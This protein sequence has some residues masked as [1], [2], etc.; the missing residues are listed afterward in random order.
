MTEKPEHQ[1]QLK[2]TTDQTFQL[3]H[4]TDLNQTNQ[5]SFK[6]MAQTECKA[7]T[8]EV[9]PTRGHASKNSDINIK[10]S[11]NLKTQVRDVHNLSL[12]HI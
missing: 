1:I 3:H 11:N 5:P 6:E 8:L 7:K 12:I 4:P 9:E 10:S 2:K